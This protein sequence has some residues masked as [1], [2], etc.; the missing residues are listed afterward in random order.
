MAKTSRLA[1]DGIW[2]QWTSPIAAQSDGI[3]FYG[4]VSRAGNIL[5][6]SFDKSTG[7]VLTNT[8]AEKFNADDHAAPSLIVRQS[9]KRI[10]FF[11]TKHND[12]VLR[13]RVSADPLDI[14]S[15]GEEKTFVGAKNTAYPQIAQLSAE[16]GRIYVFFRHATP[17]GDDRDWAFITSDDGGE[18]FGDLKTLRTNFYSHGNGVLNP[19]TVV[20]S[21]G[22][23]RIDFASMNYEQLGLGGTPN[24]IYHWYYEGGSFFKTDGARSLSMAELPITREDQVTVVCSEQHV[25]LWDV[26]VDASGRPSVLWV[27]FEDYHNRHIACIGRWN[28]AQWHTRAISPLG[29]PVSNNQGREWYSGGAAFSKADPSEVFLSIQ[30]EYGQFSVSKWR[31]IASGDWECAV[32][33]QGDEKRKN[34]RPVSPVNADP[35][36]MELL[37]VAGAYQDL[38]AYGPTSIVGYPGPQER[39]L[40]LRGFRGALRYKTEN[41]PVP[42]SATAV[43]FQKSAYDT[44]RFA[45]EGDSFVVPL[46]VQAVRVTASIR[47]SGVVADGNFSIV[48]N[49]RVHPGMGCATG[50]G[51]VL[52]AASA[53]LLVQPGDTFRCLVS[54][55]S[56]TVEGHSATWFAIEVIE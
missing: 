46:G 11:Y 23:S 29:G 3:T 2:Y 21:D 54:G 51:P 33:Y 4:W 55:P 47:F 31:E 15:W 43:S 16:G 13:W 18:T 22:V 42:G 30:G 36:A 45:S 25:N 53:V 20:F 56:G 6:S 41:Q 26:I 5:V 35:E 24:H 50:N 48:K 28:G 39:P 40:S 10:V 38:Q 44:D 49:G 14:S 37:F 19:Y 7:E 9:D 32:R 27:K 34:F 1:A 17:G 52:A 12:K 8:I